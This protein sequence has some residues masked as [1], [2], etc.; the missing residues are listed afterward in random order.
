MK[1]GANIYNKINLFQAG[2]LL[3]EVVRPSLS[4]SSPLA[5]LC[6]CRFCLKGSGPSLRGKDGCPGTCPRRIGT[7]YLSPKLWANFEI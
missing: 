1:V 2:F 5:D 7:I 4:P 6:H 3:L